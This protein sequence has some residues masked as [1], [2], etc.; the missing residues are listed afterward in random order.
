MPV[1][2]LTPNRLQRGLTLI[3]LLVVITVLAIL[4]SM[5]APSF[6]HMMATNRMAAN[7]NALAS[8][9]Q[10][11]RSEAARANRSVT[12]CAMVDPASRPATCSADWRGERVSFIDANGNSALDGSETPLRISPGFSDV[13]LARVESPAQAVALRFRSSGELETAIDQIR[14]CDAGSDQARL[15]HIAT[16]G[17]PSIETS[18]CQ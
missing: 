4:A 15:V 18:T 3:E 13:G 1:S 16:S 2:A 8:D 10:Y 12:V 11:A 6:S 17:R 9:L 5:G 14:L 7:A